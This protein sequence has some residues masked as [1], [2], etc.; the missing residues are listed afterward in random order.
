MEQNE[1]KPNFTTPSIPPHQEE[2]N[3]EIMNKWG[4]VNLA[5]EFGF[6]IALPLVVFALVGK[7]ADH[8]FGTFPWL[9]L[10]GIVLAITS[11]TV[12]MT[13]RLKGY[14]K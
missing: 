2:K 10:A 9:T 11:T 12:W 5:T 14:I 13:K 3:K 6:I 7:W 8:K 4:M 1:Q